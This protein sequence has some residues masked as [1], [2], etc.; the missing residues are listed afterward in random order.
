MSKFKKTLCILSIVALLTVFIGIFAYADEDE[1]VPIHTDCVRDYFE[2]V[3]DEDADTVAGERIAHYPA[4]PIGSCPYVSMSLLLSF[5]DAYWHDD[6]VPASYET[7]GEI[8]I[9]GEISQS[10]HF[11]LENNDV[12]R[13]IN[14]SDGTSLSDKIA[15]RDFIDARKGDFFQMY[16]IS[17]AMEK[18]NYH[19]LSLTYGLMDYQTIAF[20]EYYL[21][22]ECHFTPD[23]VAVRYMREG[24]ENTKEDVFNKAKEQ[25]Q[26]GFPVIYGGYNVFQDD[27]GELSIKDGITSHY[28]MGYKL[29][30]QEDDIVLT[31]TWNGA[32]EDTTTFYT[33]AYEYVPSII[34]L[35]INEEQFPH[36]CSASYRDFVDE[37]LTYCTCQI[38]TNHR[39]HSCVITSTQEQA[40]PVRQGNGRCLCGKTVG[41]HNYYLRRYTEA[42][43]WYECSCGEIG[44]VENHTLNSVYSSDSSM[45]FYYCDCGYTT[46]THFMGIYSQYTIL[47]DNFYLRDTFHRKSCECGYEEADPHSFVFYKFGQWICEEC[48][49]IRT[50][51]G[52]GG[53]IIMGKKEDEYDE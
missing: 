35:E 6:F 46:R 41:E 40:C 1:S 13:Q 17:L 52:G 14:F 21:Y 15:Y 12:Y 11:T 28:L 33:T 29:T 51:L 22:N 3:E 26:A 4:N 32:T 16:L 25:I 39:N 8:S 48:G 27:N 34:W 19:T 7:L 5:Y 43:H 23:Q 45:H 18:M 36:V 47:D 9:S 53:N 30:L 50:E 31:T 24:A 20:L 38:Y 42:N 10:F 2:W 37:N 49:Y 44:A